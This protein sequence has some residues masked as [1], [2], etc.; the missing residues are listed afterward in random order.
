MNPLISEKVEQAI[1]LLQEKGIDAWVTFVRETDV[2]RDPMLPMIFGQQLTWES[3]LILTRK[4]DRIA[5][6]GRFD[7]ETARNTGAYSEVLHFD[8]SIREVIGETISKLDPQQIAVNT[9]TTDVFADGLTH[10]MHAKLADYLGEKY[11]SRFVSSEGIVGSLRG[12]KTAEELR[13]LRAAVRSTEELYEDA[14]A[15][16]RP[17]R[18]EIEIHD[19]VLERTRARGLEPAWD[20]A[21]CPVVNSGPDSPIGHAH[22]TNIKVEPG[23]IVHFDFGVRQ[24]GYCSDMQRVLYMLKPS[25]TQAPEPVQRGFDTII[26]AIR[27]AMKVMKPGALGADVDA[28][29]RNTVLAA[30]YAEYMHG[31]G[32]HLGSAVH[33]GGGMISPRWGKYGSAPDVPLEAG[34][35][36]TIEPGLQVPGYGYINIE[37]DVL[38][39]EQGAEF[40][41]NPQT[42]LILLKSE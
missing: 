40:L 7:A 5:I 9:S 16:T 13:R 21:G 32:H 20:E 35:V 27:A 18:T 24:E 1:G 17:G 42:E 38:V 3:A 33:D 29:A 36:F 14:I 37:E 2:A 30:G 19:Y 25:E 11:A 15:F 34:N 10:G 6:V 39:T 31:T 41:G 26:A 12:R 8:K 28:A 4:G 23:H 22:P